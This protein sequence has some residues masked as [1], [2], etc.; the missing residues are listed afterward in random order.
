[1]RAAVLGANDGILG[2]ASLLIG[3]AAAGSS[4]SAVLLAGVAG[5][6]G[7]A[8]SMGAGEYV[9]VS[10]Q[11][12]AEA[13]DLAKESRTLDADPTGELAELTAIYE[14]RGLRPELARQVAQELMDHDALGAH[15][16]E[17]LGFSDSTK[18]RPFQAAF[19]SAAAFTVGALLPVV[20]AAVAPDAARV[21]VIAVMSL[22]FLAGLG[23]LGARA[24]DAPMGRAALRVS[25]WGAGAMA[26]TA[27]I[28]SLFDTSV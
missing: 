11:A 4:R 23:A 21:W 17:E 3:V 27:V 8:L 18:A 9:S 19:A 12:D 24:G 2:T 5:L 14:D 15:A 22:L 13:A 28:G 10:S 1:L 16:R 26:I 7:G 20:T 25:A 6:V